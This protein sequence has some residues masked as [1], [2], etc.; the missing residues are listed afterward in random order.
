MSKSNSELIT[1]VL[2]NYKEN[3]SW[4]LLGYAALTSVFTAG[5]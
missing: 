5:I 2:S 4:I 3:M 1:D